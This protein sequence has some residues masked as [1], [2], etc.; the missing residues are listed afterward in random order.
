VRDVWFRHTN[1]QEKRIDDDCSDEIIPIEWILRTV[2]HRRPFV[3]TS[4]F[5]GNLF[6][7]QQVFHPKQNWLILGFILKKAEHFFLWK[8]IIFW[9]SVFKIMSWKEKGRKPQA[10]LEH[11]HKKKIAPWSRVNCCF[12]MDRPNI[13]ERKAWNP[14]VWVFSLGNRQNSSP[15]CQMMSD[16]VV[17][18]CHFLS[19]YH[20][21]L[22]P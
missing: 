10:T 15:L 18:W 4:H 11:P 9:G 7:T 14:L 6:V 17:R 12:W 20:L 2:I 5:A 3:W 1:Q 19:F 21:L 13:S 22:V 16:D 8:K